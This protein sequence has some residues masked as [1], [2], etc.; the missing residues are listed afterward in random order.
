[1][2]R[3]GKSMKV[4]S[5]GE[6]EKMTGIK[7]YILRYW[8][9]T[10]PFIRPQHDFYGRRVYTARNLDLIFR[11]KYLIEVKNFS[12]EKTRACLLAE[13]SA[14][15]NRHYAIEASKIRKELLEAYCSLQS[16]KI[17]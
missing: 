6:V 3:S 13:L 17:S 15:E 16:C 11:I 8:E 12:L 7:S 9:N 2:G 4:F 10:V 5:I 14:P 1:M